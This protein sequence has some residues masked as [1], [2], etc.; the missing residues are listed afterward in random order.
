MTLRFVLPAIHRRPT[1]GN[2]YNRNIAVELRKMPGFGRDIALGIALVDSLMLDHMPPG[3]SVLIAH[4][5]NVVDPA[6]RN[7][8]AA[9]HERKVLPRFAGIVTTSDYSL[10]ALRD[11]GL[12]NVETVWPGLHD[13]FRGPLTGRRDRRVLLTV[14]SL[15]PN[16]GLLELIDILESLADLDWLWILAGD[17][18][19][20]SAYTRRLQDRIARS[21]LRE[22][23]QVR[24]PM[25]PS[26][27][28]ALYDRASVFVLPTRFETC[29]MATRE[30]MAR[31]LPVVAYDTGGL[32]ANLP[33]L[34]ARHL[35]PAGDA[36]AFAARLRRLLVDAGAR[37]TA[38]ERNR[39]TALTFP[40]W[41][42]SAAVL[43]RFLRQV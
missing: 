4:Y 6:R 26:R 42:E 22:R 15:L 7:S 20:D 9:A 14:A 34:S 16:K 30:A 5:L 40:T 18:T 31:A 28:V 33:P 25:P 36:A 12:V 21:P 2:V 19:L 10:Q 23:F 38:G 29:S 43:W 32:R 1:G 39:T 3:K 27:L 41:A 11:E 17:A 8:R 24:R 37:Q 35:A 13:R